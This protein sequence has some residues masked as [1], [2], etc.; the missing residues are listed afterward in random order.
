M[1]MIQHWHKEE[2]YSTNEKLK[3]KNLTDSQ[4]LFNNRQDNFGQKQKNKK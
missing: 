4:S 3:N 2:E 1:H